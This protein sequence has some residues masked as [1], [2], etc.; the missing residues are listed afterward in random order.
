MTGRAEVASLAEGW[1]V[2]LLPPP[3]ASE[4]E[5]HLTRV[6]RAARDAHQQV[7]AGLLEVYR[8]LLR[9]SGPE[10]VLAGRRVEV[11]AV[12]AL[13]GGGAS[14]LS[15]ADAAELLEV[16]ERQVRKLRADGRLR[17]AGRGRVLLVDVLQ[18]RAEQRSR[19]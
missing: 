5:R 11:D 2:I 16:K 18:W 19:A 17:P 10:A 14:W 6:W 15:V 9:L 8:Q 7:P 12:R 3:A 4:W 13:V 1:V